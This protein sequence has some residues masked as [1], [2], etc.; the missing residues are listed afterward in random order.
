MLHHLTMDTTSDKFIAHFPY[1]TVTPIIG[2][3]TY[4][5]IS[6]LDLQLNANATSVQSNLGDGLNGFLELTTTTA[7]YDAISAT[8]FVIPIN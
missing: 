7:V 8:P 6:A 3:P 4:I 5:V 2:T 1:Q